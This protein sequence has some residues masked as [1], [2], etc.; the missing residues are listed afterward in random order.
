M[1]PFWGYQVTIDILVVDWREG[2]LVVEA[3]DWGEKSNFEKWIE[4][5]P[6]N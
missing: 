6:K 4:G 2:I 5:W 1:L 3:G